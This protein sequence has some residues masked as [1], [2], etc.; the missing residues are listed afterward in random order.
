MNTLEKPE[1]TASVSN[2]KRF[3]KSGIPILKSWTRLAEKQ[4]EE[5]S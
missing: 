4:E 2:I 5:H 1:L 3:L